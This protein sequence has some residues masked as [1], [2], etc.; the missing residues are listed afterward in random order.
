MG[1][2]AFAQAAL[3]KTK[4]KV[5]EQS[6]AQVKEK[7]LTG[8]FRKGCYE[9]GG[10]GFTPFKPWGDP[11][12]EQSQPSSST[13]SFPHVLLP[14]KKEND[15]SLLC[16]FILLLYVQRKESQ[17]LPPPCTHT[18]LFSYHFTH[19]QIFPS[20]ASP[21][22]HFALATSTRPALELAG[23]LMRQA[24]TRISCF[25]FS[26]TYCNNRRSRGILALP[27]LLQAKTQEC[28]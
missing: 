3:H 2:S 21:P 13:G 16:V 28:E 26:Q 25:W 19:L 7:S 18:L 8:K 10:P 11:K 9:P 24:L 22:H 14:Y 27:S 6:L 20:A 23:N 15:A 17:C 5:L 12:A 4:W 1:I